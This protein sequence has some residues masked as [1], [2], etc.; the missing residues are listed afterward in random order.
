MPLQIVKEFRQ[1][2]PLID[3]GVYNSTIVKMEEKERNNPFK[4]NETQIG[5][6][7]EFVV[8]DD[9]YR[10]QHFWKWFN[11]ILAEGKSGKEAYLRVL[12]KAVMGRYFTPEELATLNTMEDVAK[13][14]LNKN[15]C[16]IVKHKASSKTG[17]EYANVTDFMKSNL[18]VT[19]QP[20]Q[21]P[22]KPNPIVPN[23][24]NPPMNEDIA[25]DDIP[26]EAIK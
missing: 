4:N 25:P 7:I 1:D 20:P 13:Y 23:N 21:P 6:Q 9:P 18:S 16:L 26:E 8:Q 3:E 14:I 19:N 15:V 2:F 24:Q 11:P 17:K 5:I 10:G 22:T 12:C